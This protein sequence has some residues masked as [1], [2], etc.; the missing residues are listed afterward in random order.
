MIKFT[1]FLSL[2]AFG[3]SLAACAS[4]PPD[5]TVC[6]EL[7]LNRAFCIKSVSGR[8]GYVDDVNKLYDEETKTEYTWWDLR[9]YT[10]SMPYN[11]WKKLKIWIIQQ[12]KLS[13]RCEK[14]ISSWER[15]LIN[16]DQVLEKK[17]GFQNK[18]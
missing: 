17:S 7:D 3:L 2:L 4:S 16:L 6:T 1:L 13:G 12:C 15:T 5:S 11:D 18:K 14:E 10:I 9:P 8:A